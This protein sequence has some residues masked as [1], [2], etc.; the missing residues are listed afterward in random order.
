MASTRTKN[1]RTKRKGNA[2]KEQYSKNGRSRRRVDQF[3]DGIT[4]ENWDAWKDHLANRQ[5]E[6]L[7][8]MLDAGKKSPLL[9]ALPADFHKTEAEG[10]IE[11][12]DRFTRTVARGKAPKIIRGLKEAVEPWLVDST[13]RVVHTAG[14]L[15]CLAWANA[16]SALSQHLDVTTWQS[17]LETL[18]TVVRDAEPNSGECPLLSQLIVGELPLTLAYLLPELKECRALLELARDAVTRGITDLTDGE[19]LPNG[20]H[21]DITRPLFASWTRC[22][23][24]GQRVK[25]NCY[26]KQSEMHYEWLVRQFIRLLR[27]DG[28]Q[29]FEQSPSRLPKRLLRAALKSD[30]DAADHTIASR[31]V[32]RI[33]TGHDEMPTVSLPDPSNYSEWAQLAL[34]RSHWSN[35]AQQF[36]VYFGDSIHTELY[37]Q[38]QLL[39]TGPCDPHISITDDQGSSMQIVM[40]RRI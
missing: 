35:T 7:A 25:R 12:L 8:E 40:V 3:A 14:A 22:R 16:L 18:L 37:S 24:L 31:V 33:V 21:L 17:L 26:T 30:G 39:W 4:A 5:S 28:S 13:N 10:L 29:V 2:S 19:G 20:A 1:G 27:S 15:E 23:Y 9:W 32:P 34:M 36:S 38:K 6:G 11:K